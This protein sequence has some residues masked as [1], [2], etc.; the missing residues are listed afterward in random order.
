MRFCTS[1]F[2]SS[3]NC[4]TQA[5]KNWQIKKTP[6]F[7]IYQAIYNSILGTALNPLNNAIG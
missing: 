1:D 7:G 2:F 5:I 6:Q 4:T 3:S